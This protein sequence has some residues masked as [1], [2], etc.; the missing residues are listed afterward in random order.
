[1]NGADGSR[2]SSPWSQRI[3]RPWPRSRISS[4][5]P[6]TLN[7]PGRSAVIVDRDYIRKGLRPLLGA[8]G[9]G[10]GGAAGGGGGVFKG[11]G[12]GEHPPTTTP[13]HTRPETR[14]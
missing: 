5:T 6:C 14:H 8:A 4:V 13:G 12:G 1:M 3:G 9:A 2:P 10:R 7:Q 11:S